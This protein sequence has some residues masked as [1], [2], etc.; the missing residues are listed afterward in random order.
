ML[1]GLASIRSRIGGNMEDRYLFKAKR[2]D[3]GEWVEGVP[4][5]I[6]GKTV[7]LIKDNDNL[8]RVHYIE[9]NMWDAAI[10]VIEIDP[11]TICQCTGLKDRNG[12]LIWENDI[13]AFQFY[14]DD[15]PFLN[16][17]TKKRLGKVFW[18][19]FRADFSI[20]MGHNGSNSMSN[21]L[22]KYVQNGN[23]VEVLGN[24]FDNKELFESE[25]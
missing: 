2:I 10:Y 11:S 16:K 18:Q 24:I 13:V 1:F 9:E 14:N 15:C 25:G 21:D 5:E 23:L 12:K 20:G 22:W 7:I 8:L 3:N 6:E 4:F 17:N 19:D